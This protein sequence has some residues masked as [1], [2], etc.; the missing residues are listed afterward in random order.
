M[1]YVFG[2]SH[3]CMFHGF[4]FQI[5]H[6][7]ESTTMYTISKNTQFSETKFEDNDIIIFIFG[8][9][10]IRCRIHEQI[11]KDKTIDEIIDP[12]VDNYIKYIK[13]CSNPKTKCIITAPVPPTS[14]IDGIEDDGNPEFPTRGSFRA[15]CRYHN[16]LCN[17]LRKCEPHGILL[18]NPSRI[19][20]LP[21]GEF[22]PILTDKWRCHINNKYTPIIENLFIN[23]M[24]THGLVK[25]H[26]FSNITNYTIRGYD[27]LYR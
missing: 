17:A 9:I 26:T 24:H 3:V 7:N 6:S 11:S 15:R 8:E 19:L 16:Y 5:K 18:F 2:D 20:S 1:I 21:D 22:N 10:D 12:L 13:T 27:I 23:F 25:S 4:S 14:A